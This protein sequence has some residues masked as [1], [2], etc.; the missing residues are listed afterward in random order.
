MRPPPESFKFSCDVGLSGEFQR[1]VQDYYG[2]NVL[3]SRECICEHHRQCHESARPN[4]FAAAQLS[5]VGDRYAIELDSRPWRIAIVSMQTGEVESPITMSRRREQFSQRVTEDF[6]QRNA[7]IKGV[8]SALRV[9]YGNDAGR[10]N[11]GELIVTA[12]GAVHVLNAHALINATLCSSIK[13]PGSREGQGSD[14]MHHSCVAHL[15]NVLKLL[16]PT[17]VHSQGRRADKKTA[18]PH[19]SLLEVFD[20]G[21]IRWHD[22]HVATA[23]LEGRP[24]AWVSTGHPSAKGNSA[25]QNPESKKFSES[26]GPALRRG[27][28]IA[29]GLHDQYWT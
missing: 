20:S 19:R 6:M 27:H 28:E 9:L 13:K 2:A 1:R 5:F 25:W 22:E 11:A 17:I 24:I 29:L 16:K 26:V 7:H 12:T 21:S 23:T 14:V 4:H 3:A 15:T 10:D 8:T 18:T